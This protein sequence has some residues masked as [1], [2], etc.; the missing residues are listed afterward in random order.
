MP[1]LYGTNAEETAE[2]VYVLSPTLSPT[3]KNIKGNPL[4][5]V[6]G[7]KFLPKWERIG[8]N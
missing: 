7:T 4:S 5:F 1:S 8:T 2:N 6:S 3:P